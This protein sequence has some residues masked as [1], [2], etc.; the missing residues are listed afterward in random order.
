[1]VCCCGENALGRTQW[2][3]GYGEMSVGRTRLV[4]LLNVTSAEAVEP[5]EVESEAEQ[6]HRGVGLAHLR[7]GRRGTLRSTQVLRSTLRREHLRIASL[8]YS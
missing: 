2:G 6:P 4:R 1:M 8:D 5:R 7:R 3:E